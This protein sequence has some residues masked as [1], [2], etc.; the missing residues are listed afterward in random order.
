MPATSSAL[1]QSTKLAPN[2]FLGTIEIASDSSDE[3][4]SSKSASHPHP[5][6]QPSSPTVVGSS[7]VLKGQKRSRNFAFGDVLEISSEDEGDERPMRKMRTSSP[8]TLVL[9]D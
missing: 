3:E 5:V 4:L 2:I 1:S 6:N 8:P 7:P 9:S